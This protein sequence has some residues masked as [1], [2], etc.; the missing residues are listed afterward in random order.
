[1]CINNAHLC[2]PGPY[3]R[4]NLIRSP[5]SNHN[6]PWES[7]LSCT[8]CDVRCI[9]FQRYIQPSTFTV[10]KFFSNHSQ[11]C[12]IRFFFPLST[13]QELKQTRQRRQRKRHPKSEFALFQPW[14]LT[15]FYLVHLAKCWLI[16]LCLNSKG[17]YLSSV[18][19]IVVLWSCLL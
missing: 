14:S 16:S 9:C 10:K 12:A 11:M 18:K 13:T 7:R 4:V 6:R 8:T 5:Y 2:T 15:L 3:L 17:P 1:M 19:E